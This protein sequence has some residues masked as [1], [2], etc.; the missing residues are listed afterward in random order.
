MIDKYVKDGKVAVLVTNQFGFGWYSE[1]R[2]RPEM[3]F[4]PYIVALILQYRKLSDDEHHEQWYDLNTRIEEYAKVQYPG[5][6]LSGHW[7]LDIVWVPEG[8]KFEIQEYDGN[9]S[10]ILE[11]NERWIVA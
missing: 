6:R 4:D 9:E 11:R 7:A 3:L 1:N 10:L 5:A 2:S 8:E